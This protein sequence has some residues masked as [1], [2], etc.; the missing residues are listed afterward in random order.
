M[1]R[2]RKKRTTRRAKGEG[3]VF[4]SEAK[5]YWIWRA[6]TGLKPDGGVAY[7]Q[8]SAKTQEAALQKKQEAERRQQ[9]PH[10]D[11][12][13]VGQHLDHW[14]HDV[15]KPNTRA[16]TWDRYEQVTRLHLKPRIGG[17]PLRKL[18][19]AGVTKLWAELGRDGATS[20]NVKKCSEVLASALECAVAEHKIAV[21]PTANAAK[22]KVIS[23]EVEVFGDDEVRAI[24]GASRGDPFEALYKVAVGTG[25]RQG[26]ILALERD[27][28]DTEAGT[29]RISKMLDCRDGGEFVLQPPKSKAG[30]RT[31]RLPGFALDAV[32][33]HLKGRGPGAAFTTR[34]GNYISKS[35]FV[36]S[37]WK[38]LVE[39]AK[40]KYRKFHTLRHTHASR[41]LADGVGP[42]EVAKRLG[43]RI[44]TVM[45]I[46]AHWIPSG[47]QDTAD[48]VDAI[49][50][51][52]GESPRTQVQGPQG[53]NKVEV[54]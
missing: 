38:P 21:A 39:A 54:A 11:S 36:R 42:A 40:V 45:R 14:L 15:A 25:A 8:G 48:R 50:G 20:G 5:G 32:K 26:E 41:L 7:T 24:L 33:A 43:D 46:Y 52:K 44:E 35:N 1:P 51:A 19:V 30:L 6:V 28:F 9:Q 3:A 17:V 23:G 13:T 53:G 27:D 29:V 16:N 49:Y 34:T 31:I 2:K 47:G 12:E 4:F 10:E 37:Y 22:P 18:T